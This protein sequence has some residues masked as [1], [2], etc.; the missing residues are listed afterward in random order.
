[1]AERW[2]LLLLYNEISGDPPLQPSY[3]LVFLICIV[4]IK[5]CCLI[6]LILSLLL[7]SFFFHNFYF[8]CLLL[9]FGCPATSFIFVSFV[10]DPS[11]V[12]ALSVF[13]QD[14]IIRMRKRHEYLT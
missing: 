11:F 5:H 3:I 13:F 1:M 7:L 6:L 10:T 12:C 4:V 9:F 8:L 14:F 2:T